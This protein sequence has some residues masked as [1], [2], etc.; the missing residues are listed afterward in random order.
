[1]DARGYLCAHASTEKQNSVVKK[2]FYAKL[3][4]LYGK[5]PGKSVLRD[6]YTKGYCEGIFG[7]TLRQFILRNSIIS[8][9]LRLIYCVKW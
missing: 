9:G 2:A 4:D 3:V 6:F 7:S 1:M 5:W 8:N